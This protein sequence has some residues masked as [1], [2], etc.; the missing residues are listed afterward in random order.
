[1]RND[2][3]STSANLASE[4]IAVTV[5]ICA[6][7]NERN[8]PN[9][10]YIW[11]EMSAPL[12]LLAT[13][14]EPRRS[15]VSSMRNRGLEIRFHSQIQLHPLIAFALAFLN[16]FQGHDQISVAKLTI[17]NNKYCCYNSCKLQ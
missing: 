7:S 6:M 2:S 17:D 4:C 12:P 15:R 13:L 14:L 16:T 1:M 5:A 8:A 9:E 10:K 3:C 11:R